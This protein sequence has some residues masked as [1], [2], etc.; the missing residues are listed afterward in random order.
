MTILLDMIN[1]LFERVR[2][3]WDGHFSRTATAAMILLV[4]LLSLVLIELGRRGLMPQNIAPLLPRSHYAAINIAFTFLLY[5][6]LIDLVFG[7]AKSV[8]RSVGK[9]F[10]IFSLILLRESFKDFSDMPEPLH[11]PASSEAVLHILSS[12]GGALLIFATLTFYY[13]MLYHPPITIDEKENFTFITTKKAIALFLLAIFAYL[14]VYSVLTLLENGSA[15]SFF[16]TFYTIMVFF[17]ILIVLVSVRFSH[18]YPVV[19]RNSG[20]ALATVVLRLSLAAP[21]FYNAGL[22]VGA[23]VYLLGLNAVYNLFVRATRR[24]D[25]C[26]NITDP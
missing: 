11:W 17:D 5:L 7:L 23:A 4:Y 10:E 20:F 15:H 6:E 14:G 19:F 24:P 21:A 26:R 9:Q 2:N 3:F 25:E 22:G 8:S 1:T 13:R 16:A 12:A 18:A